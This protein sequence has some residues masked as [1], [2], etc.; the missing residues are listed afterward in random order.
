MVIIPEYTTA[1]YGLASPKTA[2]YRF[3]IL[4]ARISASASDNSTP[5][6]RLYN[7]MNSSIASLGMP[8]HGRYARST[9]RWGVLPNLATLEDARILWFRDWN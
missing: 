7:S 3:R 8:H 5:Y 6:R 2:M 4:R 1:N 9:Y